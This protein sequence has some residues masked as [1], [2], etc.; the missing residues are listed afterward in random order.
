[1]VAYLVVHIVVVEN[2]DLGEF[3]FL[4][5]HIVVYIDFGVEDHIVIL[6]VEKDLAYILNIGLVDSF[7][8]IFI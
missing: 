4:E 2:I 8:Y 6:V 5:G 7:Y 3:D 1:L